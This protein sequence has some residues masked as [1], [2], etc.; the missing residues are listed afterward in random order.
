MCSEVDVNI[1]DIFCFPF[2][3]LPTGQ[4][5]ILINLSRHVRNTVGMISIISPMK[6][7]GKHQ[8]RYIMIFTLFAFTAFISLPTIHL[9][10]TELFPSVEKILNHRG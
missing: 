1:V 5:E 7:K 6:L 8:R 4:S 10:K 3:V 9:Q 2:R